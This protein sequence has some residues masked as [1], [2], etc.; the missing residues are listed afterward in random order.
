MK[1]R[2]H[3][4]TLGRRG[5]LQGAAATGLAAGTMPLGTAIWAQSD[6]EQCVHYH[7]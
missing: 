4:I 1:D 7:G 6:E 2:I 3:T 5:F